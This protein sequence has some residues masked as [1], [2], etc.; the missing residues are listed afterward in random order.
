MTSSAITASGLRKAYKD[1][2]VLDGI[3][4]YDIATETKKVRAAIGV[5]GQF[6]SVD[7][8]LSGRENLRLMADLHHLK[9]SEARRVAE[10]LL[11]RFDLGR[12]SSSWTSRRRG[13]TRAAAARCGASSA[14]WWPT[15]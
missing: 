14:S 13:W 4:G 9:G 6:A 11:S 7:E 15:A 8:L 2:V 10:D 3:A 5:T 1:K 12:G